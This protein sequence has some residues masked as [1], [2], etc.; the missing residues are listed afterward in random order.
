[1]AMSSRHPNCGNVTAP[2]QAIPTIR[3]NTMRDTPVVNE[4]LPRP[5]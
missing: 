2:K 1:V 4:T 3:M 5:V